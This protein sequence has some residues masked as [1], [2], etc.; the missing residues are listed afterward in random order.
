MGAADVN[1]VTFKGVVQRSGIANNKD[2][3]NPAGKRAKGAAGVQQVEKHITVV[4]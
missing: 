2:R 4:E 3:K 1:M